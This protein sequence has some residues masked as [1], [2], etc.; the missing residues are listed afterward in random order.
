MPSTA[1]GNQTAPSTN[2]Y[3]N[4]LDLPEFDKFAM[5]ST[6]THSRLTTSQ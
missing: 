6:A 3:V 5:T 1:N 4:I 2:L